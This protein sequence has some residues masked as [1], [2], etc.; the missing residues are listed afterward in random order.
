MSSLIPEG[1]TRMSSRIIRTSLLATLL[2]AALTIGWAPAAGAQAPVAPGGPVLV[3]DQG[4]GFAD[5]YAEILRAEG[6]NEFD[7]G[8]LTAQSLAS[9]QVVL[10][11]QGNYAAQA[12]MLDTWVRGGGNLIAMR[13]TAALARDARARRDPGR[14]VRTST[15]GWP[16]AAASPATRC[17]STARRTSGPRRARRR[18]RRS[19]RT[20]TRRRR[21]RPSRCAA[22]APAR[23]PPSPSTWRARSS[24]RARATRPGPAWS[25]T[26]CST[27]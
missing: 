22:W 26:S 8:P 25:A 24:T 5:Y 23:P 3:V 14:A 13:P 11:S 1:Q 15:C 19:T 17:S 20:R 7:V 12:A 18:S 2:I 21:A 4:D 16:R 10:L 9:H 6:L 27:R